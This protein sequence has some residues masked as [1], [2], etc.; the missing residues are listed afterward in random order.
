MQFPGIPEVD[1]APT[2][3]VVARVGWGLAWAPG[4]LIF[5]LRPLVDTVE[6]AP[7]DQAV[8]ATYTT[9][10]YNAVGPYLAHTLDGTGRSLVRFEDGVS[11]TGVT[12][13]FCLRD[14]WHEAFFRGPVECAL[15]LIA[16]C[17][18]A[19]A[20]ECPVAAAGEECSLAF[21]THCA[22]D[23]LRSQE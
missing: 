11:T 19:C 9:E 20:S 1:A 3:R 2:S 10:T 4:L 7:L 15:N 16:R 13:S 14:D 8:C 23:C 6:W 5:M 12:D 21:A 22:A 17:R 18:A